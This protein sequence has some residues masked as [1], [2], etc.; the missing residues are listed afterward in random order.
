MKIFSAPVG[1]SSRHVHLSLDHVQQLFGT[2]HKLTPMKALLQ[3]R[4]FACEESVT[5][6]SPSGILMKNVRVLGPARPKSQVE[7]SMSD[8]EVL[9]MDVPI[10]L[11]GEHQGSPGIEIVG[12]Y[13]SVKL[14]KGVIIAARH[15]HVP[16]DFARSCGMKDKSE[17][18]VEIPGTRFSWLHHV[19]VRTGLRSV[20]ELHIDTDEANAVGVKS[21]DL[22]KVH[23]ARFGGGIA[24]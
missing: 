15:I 24:I 5:L 1:V 23:F 18:S 6:V 3:P 19:N 8:A 20:T 7:L 14:E 17:V 12:P 13:G 21:N 22:V 16:L 2:G 9:S 10:R 11:S 4:E